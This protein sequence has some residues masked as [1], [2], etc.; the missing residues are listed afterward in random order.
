[1]DEVTNIGYTTSTACDPIALDDPSKRAV[2]LGVA[3][4]DC[5]AGGSGTIQ[6]KGNAKL[7]SSYKD[8]SS[9]EN[10]NFESHSGDGKSGS[11]VGRS[12]II[13]E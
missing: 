7:S 2:F 4:T 5:P 9:A 1:M 12:V 10:F 6:T 13:R 11:Q 8:A 3:V